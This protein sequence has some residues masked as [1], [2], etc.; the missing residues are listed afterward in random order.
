MRIAVEREQRG[1]PARYACRVVHLLGTSTTIPVLLGAVSAGSV[2]AALAHGA[3]F[4]GS[5]VFGE[6]VSRGT[7]G[8][9]AVALTF[10]D[11]PCPGPTD[12]V[13]DILR[14]H[15]AT[16]AFFVIG[17]Y[18]RRHPDLL[19]RMHQEGHLVCNHSHDHS[20]LGMFRWAGYW[21]EQIGRCDGAIAESLGTAWDTQCKLF[22]PPMGFKT[23]RMIR[24]ARRLGY[25]VVT[26][27]VRSRDGIETNPDRVVRAVSP[28]ARG[29]DVILFHDGSDPASHR[30][31]HAVVG[32][33]PRVI[34]ELRA[35]SLEISRLDHLLGMAAPARGA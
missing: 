29:G 34:E 32:A 27:S 33:L 12:A 16:G 14:E 24:A 4:P 10:D 26:W 19:R 8:G 22:R 5:R 28:R 21:R 1:G 13:L 20:R 6:V 23:P 30:K 7:P 9:P 3:F 15:G 2:L 18:A 25:T 11:G 31:G 35:R 17:R